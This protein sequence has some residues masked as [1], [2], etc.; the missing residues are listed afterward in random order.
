MALQF[1]SEDLREDPEII[2]AALRQSGTALGFVRGRIKEDPEVLSMAIGFLERFGD[3]HAHYIIG[4]VQVELMAGPGGSLLFRHSGDPH[5]KAEPVMSLFH[6]QARQHKD[7]AH[8]H[9]HF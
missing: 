4:S 7:T 8:P 1:A 3:S 9:H 6:H 5:G 2:V